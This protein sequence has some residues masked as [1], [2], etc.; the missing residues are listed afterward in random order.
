MGCG[1]TNNYI[2][3]PSKFEGGGYIDVARVFTENDYK[4][5]IDSGEF[6]ATFGNNQMWTIT[7]LYGGRHLGRWHKDKEILYII[8]NK[9]LSNPLVKWLKDN[10]FVSSSEKIKLQD[11]GGVEDECNPEED[12]FRNYDKL[13]KKVQRIL[14]KYSDGEEY[15]DLEDALSELEPLGYTFDYGLDAVPYNLRKIK[16]SHGGVLRKGKS[17]WFKDKSYK[18]VHKIVDSGKKASGLRSGYVLKGKGYLVSAKANDITD[19]RVYN[20]R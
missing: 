8:G 12:L 13:P 6:K 4:A 2:K 10:L 16:M 5:L 7:K 15:S 18:G 19:K 9:D 17:V 1:C 20:V 11:G 14:A 3:L